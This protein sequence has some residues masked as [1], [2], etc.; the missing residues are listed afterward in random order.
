MRSSVYLE[1]TIISY[2]AARRSRDVI[3]AANQRLTRDWWETRSTDFDL[4]ISRTVLDEVAGG[5][6]GAAQRRLLLV[7]GLRVLT[8]ADAEVALAQKL[9]SALRLPA[10]AALD[11]LHIA[12]AAIAGADFLLTWNC[13]HI[14]NATHRPAI[15]SECRMGGYAVP[16]ICTPPELM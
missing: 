6:G 1:T 7:R 4:M 14:A 16:L 10:R 9:A 8:P 11:A 12:T 13:A 3:V 5:D 2:L 15:E